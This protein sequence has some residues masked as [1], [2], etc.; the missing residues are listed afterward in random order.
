MKKIKVAIT[1]G[2]SAGKTSF[3]EVIEKELAG[4]ISIV[5]EAATVLYRGG[6]PRKTS[7]VGRIH[8][9]RAIYFIQREFENL[10]IAESSFAATI[11]D[12][13]SLDSI[14]Y[15]PGK[16]EDFFKSLATDRSK[17]LA[18]YD[19]VLHL[20]TAAHNHFDL[21]NPL[22]I[23]SHLEALELNKKIKA[24]WDGHPQRITVAHEED[25]SIKIDRAK[26]VVQQILDGVSF[27]EI[28]L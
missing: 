27:T 20:D 3:I 18:R 7:T 24:A 14:A 4:K 5:S 10:V 2:P 22:R 25:F 11:C 15:W 6:F 12:R 1:G 23:E 8:A 26:R 21:S 13:G 9:Q 19:W 17:E 28:S 16:E